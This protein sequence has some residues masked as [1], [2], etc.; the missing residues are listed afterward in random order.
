MTINEYA[1]TKGIPFHYISG[2]S[3]HQGG[4]WE[5]AILQVSF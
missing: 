4:L 5:V 3:P 1:S 2:Y